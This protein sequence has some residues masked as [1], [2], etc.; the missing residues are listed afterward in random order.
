M[1]SADQVTHQTMHDSQCVRLSEQND[2]LVL[3][4]RTL[5]YKENK[6]TE[7]ANGSAFVPQRKGGC[8]INLIPVF[9]AGGPP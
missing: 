3:S 5:L 9:A 4:G 2:D 8:R 6:G 1:L 7:F